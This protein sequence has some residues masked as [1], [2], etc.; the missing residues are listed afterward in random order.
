ML[1]GLLQHQH[2]VHQCETRDT[3]Q[4]GGAPVAVPPETPSS[5]PSS[6]EREAGHASNAAKEP[7]TALAS[8]P[9][10][11]SARAAYLK[12]ALR[13]FGKF[14]CT[15]PCLQRDTG[16]MLEGVE[17]NSSVQLSEL[18]GSLLHQLQGCRLCKP[19]GQDAR[20]SSTWTTGLANS[21]C[22]ASLKRYLPGL[23]CWLCTRRA[24]NGV[25]KKVLANV[26]ITSAHADPACTNWPCLISPLREARGYS[27]TVVA[28]TRADLPAFLWGLVSSKS[29]ACSRS[30][31]ARQTFQGQQ[32]VMAARA[33]WDRICALELL[34]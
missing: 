6:T 9:S 15:P 16:I 34:S 22:S 21:A 26:R 24:Y 31:C 11:L 1:Q 14:I 25:H 18:L 32:A 10:T 30:P 33:G 23:L 19:K 28:T 12:V 17:L 3:P 13:I 5:R 8:P 27:C 20:S 7:L 29:Y 2:A 4:A